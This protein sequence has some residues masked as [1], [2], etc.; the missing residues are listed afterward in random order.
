MKHYKKP[1]E[2]MLNLKYK[3]NTGDKIQYTKSISQ[4]TRRSRKSISNNE[5]L[6]IHIWSGYLLLYQGIF[7]N[8]QIW[9]RSDLKN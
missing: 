5:K 8:L 7:K 3:Y 9:K 1:N 2:I 4:K 6:N